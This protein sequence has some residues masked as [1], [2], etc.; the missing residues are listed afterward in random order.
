MTPEEFSSLSAWEMEAMRVAVL[1]R[2]GVE[3]L[4]ADGAFD[5]TQSPCL[6]RLFRQE[7]YQVMYATRRLDEGN[8]EEFVDYLVEVSQDGHPDA[9]DDM[10]LQCLTGAVARAVGEFA[11]EQDIDERIAGELAEAAQLGVLDQAEAEELINRPH[12]STALLFADQRVGGSGAF[13]GLPRSL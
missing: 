7:A 3:N 9:E 6:N 4:H 8:G 10:R 1:A 12:G 5:D 11:E 2:N 13:S